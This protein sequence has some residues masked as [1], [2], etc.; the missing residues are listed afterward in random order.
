[1]AV[2][3]THLS[4]GLLHMENIRQFLNLRVLKDPFNSFCMVVLWVFLER[5]MV[6]LALCCEHIDL[7]SFF[8]FVALSM[9]ISP[10]V[11][12]QITSGSPG[13]LQTGIIENLRQQEEQRPCQCSHEGKG[14]GM[15]FPIVH[16]GK[17]SGHRSHQTLRL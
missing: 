4:M 17:S 10:S 16:T 8:I 12:P 14:S 6:V 13:L 3:V 11:F 5:G 7:F 9:N 2:P 1:M 15:S